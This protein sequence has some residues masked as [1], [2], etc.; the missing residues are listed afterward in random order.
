MLLKK[1][2]VAY[3]VGFI[4][5][6]NI[7]HVW[8]RA[9]Y[10]V[11]DL[12]RDEKP[13]DSRQSRLVR[14]LPVPVVTSYSHPT[15][16]VLFD[17][18]RDANPF[19]HL[20]EALW[21]LAG[22]DDAAFLDA[23][24]ADYSAR[25]AEEGGRQHGAY[26]FRWRHHFGRDQLEECIHL[27]RTNPLDRQAVIQMWDPEYDLGVPGLK[28]RPCNT[29]AYLRADRG[30]LDLTVLCR[31]ND[32][33]WG[34]YGA[35]SVHFSVLQ[36]YLAARI[37]LPVGWMCQVSNNWHIYDDAMHL[38][39]YD[40]AIAGTR[41]PYPGTLPLVED[42]DSFD[43]ELEAYLEDPESADKR[44]GGWRNSIFLK[45][46][47]PMWMAN[48]LRRE[49]DYDAALDYARRIAAPD[50]REASVAWIERRKAKAL[51]K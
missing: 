51:A 45:T 43:E 41:V 7:N 19:F 3:G 29:T 22:R 23:F 31:S 46:A 6:R 40:S 18:V 44:S 33:V 38:V 49:K 21:M 36:E 14:A 27:L 20:H 10:L 13:V 16:R 9:V 11:N 35:N 12:L 2:G 25:F 26:G 15:E 37:G 4:E 42:P 30:L 48:L 17:P 5:A 47:H 1:D 24:V 32:V 50:W 39:N 34:A 8:F 28:D